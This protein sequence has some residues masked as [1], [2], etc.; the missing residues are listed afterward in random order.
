MAL[1]PDPDRIFTKAQRI[2]YETEA[3]KI[4]DEAFLAAKKLQRA[5]KERRLVREV[6]ISDLPEER[7]MSQATRGTVWEYG[8]KLREDGA[9]IKLSNYYVDGSP[10]VSVQEDGMSVSSLK[11]LIEELNLTAGDFSRWLKKLA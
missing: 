10:S 7:P 8:L 11:E 4:V 3:A 1:Y 6:I 2:A 5:A 9:W